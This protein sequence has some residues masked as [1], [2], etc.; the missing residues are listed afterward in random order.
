MVTPPSSTAGPTKTVARTGSTSPAQISPGTPASTG[1]STATEISINTPSNTLTSTAFGWAEYP[2]ATIIY[3]AISG[4][5][6]WELR[7]QLDALGPVGYDGY[8]GD[9]ATNW[10]IHWSWP[11]Y[12]SNTCDLSKAVVTYD[13]E[14]VFPRWVPPE[15][16]PSDLV[17][18]WSIYTTALAE[19]EKGHIDNVVQNYQSVLDAIMSATCETAEAA[20]AA[21]LG[22]LRQFDI[23]Y[24][25]AT[26]HGETQ[27]ARFP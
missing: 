12:G 22:P 9:A 16:A 8:Q 10:F 21:A 26:N 20:A 3:Y 7:A 5:S 11:G 25:A 2:N 1:T 6:A 17:D 27:G 13:I 24:D 19:H 14:V 18:R 15:D 23:D 4:S